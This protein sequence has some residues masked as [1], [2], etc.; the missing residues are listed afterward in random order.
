[1][2]Q[3]EKLRCSATLPSTFSHTGHFLQRITNQTIHKF[4]VE[5]R[6]S[7]KGAYK[8]METIPSNVTILL[9]KINK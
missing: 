2:L 4:R 5:L 1:M 8:T 9:K 3:K 6:H 7:Y